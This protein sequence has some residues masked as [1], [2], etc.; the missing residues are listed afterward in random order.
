MCTSVPHN[1]RR[2]VPLEA[3]TLVSDIDETTSSN[4]PIGRHLMHHKKSQI[5]SR[6]GPPA[7]TPM[8][9]R[10]NTALL[11]VLLVAQLMVILDI[12]A[13]KTPCR[14]SRKDLK[15][16]GRDDQLDD[17]GLLARLRGALLLG[18][19]RGRPAWAR[20]DGTCDLAVSSLAWALAGTGRLA[21]GAAPPPR[22]RAP[23][24]CR[25]CRSS[26]PASTA[27][28]FDMGVRLQHSPPVALSSSSIC[29]KQLWRGKDAISDTESWR[30]CLQVQPSRRASGGLR[31]RR[32]AG[33]G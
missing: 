6:L 17:H 16:C 24:A 12:T 28:R 4:L 22:G 29:G 33:R 10:K 19:P 13:V 5:S 32:L 9:S 31:D 30:R 23:L 20:P 18:R 7:I 1:G 26:R 3:W 15:I 25:G 21:R 27:R 11:L 2:E 8:P 14:A